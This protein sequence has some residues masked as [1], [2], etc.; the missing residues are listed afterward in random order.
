[1]SYD[2][3]SVYTLV[4]GDG[5]APTAV[6]VHASAEDAWRALDREVRARCGLRPRPKRLV[7]ENAVTRLADA[8]RAGDIETRFW[9]IHPHQ[10]PIMVP[11][12]GR[13]V[14]TTQC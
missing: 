10:L 6:S 3:V 11:E 5:E 1:M 7:D 2:V 12:I 14:S 9:Q 4:M 13:R 8:W